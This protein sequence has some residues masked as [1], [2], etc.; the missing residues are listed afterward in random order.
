MKTDFVDKDLWGA[1]MQCLTP[2]NALVCELALQTGWR[3]DD[4]L[5]LR[6]SVLQE[7]R[8][9]EKTSITI[10]EQKTGKKSTKRLSKRLFDDLYRQKGEY[11]VFQGR[12]C[13]LTHRT[14]QAVYLDLKRARKALR[15]KDNL[16]PH[17]MRKAYAVDL[18]EQTGSLDKVQ[19]ALNHSHESDT[20]IYALSDTYTQLKKRTRKR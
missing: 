10:Y 19:R 5:S 13:K 18:L 20:L 6:S 2:A 7:A 16:A 11:Y 12:D 3:V 8:D 9:K 4:C 17:T 14:R 1:I 15:I